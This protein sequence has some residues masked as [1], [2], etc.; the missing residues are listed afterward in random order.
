MPVIFKSFLMYL[1]S[2]LLFRP[3]RCLSFFEK[4]PMPFI[5]RIC[6]RNIALDRKTAPMIYSNL[7]LCEKE[8]ESACQDT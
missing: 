5:L 3:I 4:P 8:R 2:L 6:S 1:F 7:S